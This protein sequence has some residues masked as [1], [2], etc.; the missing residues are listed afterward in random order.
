MGKLTPKSIDKRPKSSW[1]ELDEFIK[2]VLNNPAIDA[3][4]INLKEY[5]MSKEENIS[6]LK[7]AGY[8]VIDSN[9]GYLA[10]S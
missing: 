6:E 5:A 10:V 7:L 4:T 9:D 3:A 1:D 8:T 2:N